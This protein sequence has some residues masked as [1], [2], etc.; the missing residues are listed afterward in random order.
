MQF[1]LNESILQNSIIY[2][3]C[4]ILFGC[5]GQA[6]VA[7]KY[8]ITNWGRELFCLHMI[9]LFERKVG[10]DTLQ[11]QNI[12]FKIDQHQH[13]ASLVYKTSSLY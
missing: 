3:I 5:W 2:L 11:V 13:Y 12:A 9:S 4:L 1:S 7:R 6:Y 8:E 10:L